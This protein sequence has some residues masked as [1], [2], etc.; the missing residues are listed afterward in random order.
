VRR[1][2]PD[3]ASINQSHCYRQQRAFSA[4][5]SVSF[6]HS[7]GSSCAAFPNTITYPILAL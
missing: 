7:D 6:A 2:S 3:S 1:V 4:P 5:Y